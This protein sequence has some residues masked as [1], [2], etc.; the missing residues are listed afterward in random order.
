M[1]ACGNIRHLSP[2]RHRKFRL[3]SITRGRS[4][5]HTSSLDW[6]AS[7]LGLEM[8]SADA[9]GWGGAVTSIS[10]HE[11]AHLLWRGD[12]TGISSVPTHLWNPLAC[13]SKTIPAIKTVNYQGRTHTHTTV[14]CWMLW[15]SNLH[16]WWCAW[17]SLARRSCVDGGARVLLLLFCS[18]NDPP[19]YDAPHSSFATTYSTREHGSATR[20]RHAA[21]GPA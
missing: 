15:S 7:G 21:P 17:D 1:A 5:N 14:R 8:L 3:S 12:L 10:S 6:H 4:H 18:T 2:S 9:I 11:D 13:R 20:L 16:G 19:N